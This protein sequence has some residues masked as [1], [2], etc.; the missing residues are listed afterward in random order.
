VKAQQRTA[1]VLGDWVKTLPKQPD[2]VLLLGDNF[3]GTLKG[4]DEA[5]WDSTFRRVYPPVLSF[6]PLIIEYRNGLLVITTTIF[7]ALDCGPFSGA[8]G[9]KRSIRYRRSRVTPPA[10]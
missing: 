9:Q 10:D 8:G 3:Y 1:K 5:R 6:S 7:R 2:A 4:V